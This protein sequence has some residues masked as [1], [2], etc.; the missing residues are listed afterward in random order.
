MTSINLIPAR[1]REKAARSRQIRRWI[2]A[3][4]AYALLNQTTRERPGAVNAD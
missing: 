4:I 3:G 2:G 1:W